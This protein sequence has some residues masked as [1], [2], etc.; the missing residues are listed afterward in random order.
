[1]AKFLTIILLLGLMV[2]CSSKEDKSSNIVN[3]KFEH[4]GVQ[5]HLFS[6]ELEELA[7]IEATSLSFDVDVVSS[8]LTWERAVF[9]FKHYYNIHS[10]LCYNCNSLIVDT[11]K[12]TYQI[13]RTYKEGQ[14]N[15][16]ISAKL[17][18]PKIKDVNP[19]LAA[20]NL[21][22]FVSKGLLNQDLIY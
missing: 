14:A 17:V 5:Y 13:S 1:M 18:D 19:E 16:K 10:D 2:A 11:P 9:F 21:A 4:Q 15:F 22:R 8:A 12:L 6:G 20:K 3:Q 7:E